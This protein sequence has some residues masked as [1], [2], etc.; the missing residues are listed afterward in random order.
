MTIR[1]IRD[2]TSFKWATVTGTAPLAIRLDGDTAPLALIPD[3]LV[4]PL[5]LVVGDR[6]RVELSLRKVVIHGKSNGVATPTPAQPWKD[7]G[8]KSGPVSWAAAQKVNWS[9]GLDSG[10]SIDAESDVNEI[11]ILADGIYDVRAVQR[12]TTSSDYITLG[13]N[14]DRL[15]LENRLGGVFTHD[16]AAGANNYSTATYFG[17]LLA[18]ESITAGANAA[19]GGMVYASSSI[20]GSIIINRV[21]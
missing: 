17:Q 2:L 7:W 18:G 5:L 6:V 11:L 4:D 16:H 14:G 3:S 19:G 1:D 8:F 21:S 10:G 20:T 13:L 12:G 9:R 15:T